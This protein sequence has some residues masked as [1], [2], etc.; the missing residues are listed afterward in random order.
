MCTMNNCVNVLV[1]GIRNAITSRSS[2]CID[3]DVVKSQVIQ[4][5]WDL[6]LPLTKESAVT[7]RVQHSFISS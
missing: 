6:A 4:F 2:G 7:G 1:L 3:V 5:L